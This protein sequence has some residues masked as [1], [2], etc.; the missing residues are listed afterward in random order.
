MSQDPSQEPPIDV[1]L[2]HYVETRALALALEKAATPDEQGLVRGL[3]A[4]RAA[5]MEKRDAYLA[6]AVAKRHARGEVYS[7]ARVAAINAIG[8]SRAQLDDD[9]NTRLA[10]KSSAL[11]VLKSQARVQ[12]AFSLV[13]QRLQLADLP[14]DMQDAA[15]HML[16]YEERFARA[17]LDAVGDAALQAEVRNRQREL[18][19]MLRT[20]SRPMYFVGAGAVSCLDDDEA[21][22]LGKVWAK[23][24]AMGQ[25]LGLE[26]LS[27]FIA[28]GDEGE[29]ANVNADRLLAVL[30]RL[31]EAIQRPEVKF[32]AKN[33][34]MQV[35]Q[36]ICTALNDPNVSG[37]GGRF[38]VD[39]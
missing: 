24:E 7:A 5:L 35:L 11:D 34:T 8:P 17:W 15:R 38:E 36:K 2:T 20:A 9:I 39:I 6:L 32:P 26:S 28:V 4:H 3:M 29:A 23:L 27:Q 18:L 33:K 16:E 30:D 1:S 31:R 13:S 22:D 37:G 19:V 12:F 21:R 14:A 25:S 10:R